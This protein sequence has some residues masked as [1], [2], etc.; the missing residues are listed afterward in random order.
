M[1]RKYLRKKRTPT[2]PNRI[3]I[4]IRPLEINERCEFGHFESDLIVSSKS[5]SALNVSVERVSRYTI[6]SKLDDKTSQTNADTIIS[7]HDGIP[8]KSF[9]YDNGKENYHHERVNKPLN[10]VSFFCEPYHSWKKGSVENR[11]ALIRRFL[12]KKID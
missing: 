1:P 11:N 4:S 5:S 2:I 8:V 10:C 3:P 9:T 12:P 7:S 6:I